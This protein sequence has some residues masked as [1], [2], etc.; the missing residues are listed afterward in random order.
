M[1]AF[2]LSNKSSMSQ[3][4]IAT[5]NWQDGRKSVT[6]PEQMAKDIFRGQTKPFNPPSKR[7]FLLFLFHQHQFFFARLV[8]D[9]LNSGLIR[10]FSFASDLI[11]IQFQISSS[12][13]LRSFSFEKMNRLFS[14]ENDDVI[15][16]AYSYPDLYRKLEVTVSTSSSQCYE[17]FT[18]LYSQ[19]C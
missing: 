1:K 9:F 18:G 13:S 5:M 15:H 14:F 3:H 2:E 17:A 7:N 12:P 8:L 16:F 19:V 4:N 10:F 6:E 11:L